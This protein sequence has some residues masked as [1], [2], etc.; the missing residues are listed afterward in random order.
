ML[1]AIPL[2]AILLFWRPSLA[3]WYISYVVIFNMLVGPVFLAGMMTGERERQTL[4]LLLTTIIS[5][6]QILWGKLLAGLRVSAVL[7][8]FLLWPVLLASILVSA[9]WTNWDSVLV[10]FAIILTT[11]I[12]SS[13]VALC[14]SVLFQR[15]SLSLMATYLTLL[16][17]YAMPLVV[18]A[19]L[20]ILD[21]PNSTL[22]RIRWT[23]A[24]SPFTAAFAVPL[25][26][27]MTVAATEFARGGDPWMLAAYFFASALLAGILM[28]AMLRLLE[29]RWRVSAL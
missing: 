25:D 1:L 29:T 18:S 15:T 24:L 21:F 7:T 10:Y 28:V 23:S 26:E 2:M 27:E 17:L 8:S 12:V 5:P 22:M 3:P 20:R 11:C 14:C 4:D 9:Y 16:V 13:V 19:L 6:W